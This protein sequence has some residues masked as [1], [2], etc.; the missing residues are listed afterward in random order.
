MNIFFTSD[1][2]FWHANIIN[3]C[4]RPFDSVAEM[5]D[6]LIENW[7]ARVQH[8]DI[9]YVLG[10]MFF[11]DVSAARGIMHRLHGTKRLV[12]GNHD[13]LIR[14]EPSLQKLFDKILPDLHAETIQGHAVVMCHYPLL[15][16]H[17]S[18][19]G[20]FMLHGHTHGRITHGS[21]RR[22][23]VG[24]DSHVKGHAA[25]APWSWNEICRTL[26]KVQ[27]DGTDDY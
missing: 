19:K 24:V 8:D 7:N 16:W 14:A 3:Y 6:A 5:N 27:A 17:K 18:G 25:F 9:V 1:L 26:E 22:L 13:K 10:D 4:Q 23:D 11:C 12:L 20:A 21:V 15:T 2:H